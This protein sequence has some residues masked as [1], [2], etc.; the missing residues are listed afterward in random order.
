MLKEKIIKLCN[1]FN[2]KLSEDQISLIVKEYENIDKDV[3]PGNMEI[4]A[5]IKI[6]LE[7]KIPFNNRLNG[8][9]DFSIGKTSLNYHISYPELNKIIG[10]LTSELK[11]EK[12][13]YDTFYSYLKN[14]FIEA[15]VKSVSIIIENPNL[16]KI[17]VNDTFIKDNMP[18]FDELGFIIKILSD[19]ELN[20]LFPYK[21]SEEKESL[22]YYAYIL[23]DKYLNIF[24]N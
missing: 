22:R 21:T 23:R 4:L 17:A 1:D 12:L 11:N 16:N 19:E 8:L 13:I 15:L 24:G 7:E 14:N 5:R 18:L 3:N 10:K 20:M 6:M 9:L 2:I